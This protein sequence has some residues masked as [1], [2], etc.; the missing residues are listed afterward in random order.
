MRVI[1]L[2][3]SSKEEVRTLRKLLE[4]PG[5]YVHIRKP[6]ITEVAFGRY[7]SQFSEADRPRL[8]T[9]QHYAIALDNG[10]A[11]MHLPAHARAGLPGASPGVYASTSTHGWDEFNQLGT[12]FRSAFIGPVFPSISKP[13][14]GT[15]QQLAFTGR[16][17]FA[18]QAIAL[19][20]I[21]AENI[22]ALSDAHFDD[23]ALCGAIW[24]ARDPLQE[25]ARCYQLLQVNHRS[26]KHDIQ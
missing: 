16:T 24:Q 12:A 9:H 6:L 11:H 7:L 19:G 3:E 2:N 22:G 13:G 26:S 21:S 20:G 18:M 14:Y 15:H 23:V 4:W 5:I 8:I 17:N 10:V 25:A 1:T